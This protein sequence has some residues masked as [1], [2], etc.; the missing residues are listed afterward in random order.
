MFFN[1]K[2]YNENI[3]PGGKKTNNKCQ[4]Y[5]I[6]SPPGHRNLCTER[7]KSPFSSKSGGKRQKSP[8]CLNVEKEK[9]VPYCQL[10]E[11]RGDP[12]FT[13]IAKNRK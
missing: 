2:P 7:R 5:I 13:N 10:N 6:T 3:K 11:V 8:C 1:L 9:A 12:L 4:K